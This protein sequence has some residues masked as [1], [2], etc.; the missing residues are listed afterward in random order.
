MSADADGVYG[1]DFRAR[2]PERVNRRNGY[3]ER[4]WDTR[5]GSSIELAVPK[6]RE[7]GE[8]A[9]PDRGGLPH[10]AIGRRPYGQSRQVVYDADCVVIA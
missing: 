1:A 5:V 9:R 8:V 7:V 3:W 10:P 6:L 2:S 4:P